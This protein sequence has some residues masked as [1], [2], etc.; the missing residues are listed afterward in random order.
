M[1]ELTRSVRIEELTFFRFLAAMV[2]VNFHYGLPK[3]AGLDEYSIFSA[4]PQMV[5]FFF[6]LSG[7]VMTVAYLPKQTSLSRYWWTRFARI[8]PVY[9]AALTVVIIAFSRQGKPLDPMA[10]FLNFTFLQAW[11]PDY[12]LSLNYPGWSISV[13]AFFYFSFPI[14]IY[15]IKKWQLP[16]L[17][18]LKI[19][20][21]TW[22]IT[23]LATSSYYA[24]AHAASPG[25]PAFEKAHDLVHYLPLAHLN[26]FL[27]GIAGGQFVLARGKIIENQL[28]ST[29]AFMAVI[30]MIALLFEYQRAIFEL[31][32]GEALLFNTS[33]FAPIFFILI[34]IVSISRSRIFSLF[35]WKPFVVLGDASYSLYILQYPAAIVFYRIFDNPLGPKIHEVFP[36]FAVAL[37]LMAVFSYFFFERPAKAALMQYRPFKR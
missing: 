34:L 33:I 15:A 12:P 14:L 36:F 19:A 13:E 17:S 4:G 6:V 35:A 21:A 9:L 23:M 3:S 1:H 29:L 25:S 24:T 5:T 18:T 11:V 28:F 16:W 26:S 30:A 27:F 8:A 10:I 7:L 20:I 31:V 32:F 22:A 2:V 37:T